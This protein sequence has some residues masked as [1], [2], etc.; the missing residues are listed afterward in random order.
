MIHFEML[1]S[2]NSVESYPL[3]HIANPISFWLKDKSLILLNIA[4]VIPPTSHPTR[5]PIRSI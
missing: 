1:A 5:E 2:E 4:R 3:H